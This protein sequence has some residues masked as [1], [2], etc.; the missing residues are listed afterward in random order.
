MY[1][2]WIPFYYVFP[3]N[4]GVLICIY[5][6]GAVHSLQRNMLRLWFVHLNDEDRYYQIHF[7]TRLRETNPASMSFLELLVGRYLGIPTFLDMDRVGGYPQR[8]ASAWSSQTQ[9]AQ[10]G[11]VAQIGPWPKS[12]AQIGG[13]NR[14]PKSV[15]QIGPDL[16]RPGVPAK[17]R[18]PR[19][20][21]KLFVFLT[22]VQ[23]G[24]KSD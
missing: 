13:P 12:V 18:Q 16:T 5:E 2:I 15:A 24:W 1:L 3:C 21:Y 19:N 8:R 14:W 11:S 20:L 9:L 4:L 17:P 6:L 7:A 23:F 10:I 22:M